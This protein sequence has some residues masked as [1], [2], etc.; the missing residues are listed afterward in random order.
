MNN[1]IFCKVLRL[2][3]SRVCTCVCCWC[4]NVKCI[5][6]SYAIASLRVGW[7]LG[8]F[9]TKYV[10]HTLRDFNF[11]GAESI[12]IFAQWKQAAWVLIQ[13]FF[14]VKL[15]LQLSEVIID[16][17]NRK[18]LGNSGEIWHTVSRINLLQN[19]LNVFLPHLNNVS[20]LLGET[21][22]AHCAVKWVVI[23]KELQNLSHL[24]CALQLRQIWIRLITACEKYCM[25]RCTK[26][27][28]L[29]WSYQ[30]RHWG[31]SA[32]M[33]T[34]SSLAHSVLSLRFSSFRSMLRIL[35]T[36]SSNARHM[37]Q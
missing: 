13:A 21:W 29:I 36:F 27:A 6:C 11:R 3:L 35:Y 19:D 24:N 9:I 14:Q 5:W 23:E 33:T 37:L 34:W 32:A 22:S 10:I 2:T 18:T 15:K 1:V 17:A 31:M 20:T 7:F 4:E 26:H 16:F 25:K 12:V 28:S 8:C 30:R